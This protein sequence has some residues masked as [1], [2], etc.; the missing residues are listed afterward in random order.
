[1]TGNFDSFELPMYNAYISIESLGQQVSAWSSLT[2]QP[3]IIDC[4]GRERGGQTPSIN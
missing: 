3:G 4:Q 1:M 2:E